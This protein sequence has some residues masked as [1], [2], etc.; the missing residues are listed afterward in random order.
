MAE[1]LFL[2][3]LVIF[4]LANFYRKYKNKKKVEILTRKNF[5][6]LQKKTKEVRLIS[7][8]KVMSILFL[9][10]LGIAFASIW[11]PDPTNFHF[12]KGVSIFIITNSV[13]ELL[14][15]SQKYQL[16]YNDEVFMY[17]GEIYKFNS[18]KAIGYSRVLIQPGKMHFKD[19]QSIVLFKGGLD[20]IHEIVTNKVQAKKTYI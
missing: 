14:S 19:G 5:K 8:E 6:R 11:L 12:V 18:I 4:S 15:L 7:Q 2:M 20:S 10:I 17:Q 3:V 9:V 13:I 16:Y 1:Y